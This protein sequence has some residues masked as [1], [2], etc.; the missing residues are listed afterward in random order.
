MEKIHK[1]TP[2]VLLAVIAM[3]G[4]FIFQLNKE[5]ENLECDLISAFFAEREYTYPALRELGF[6]PTELGV[7]VD[8]PLT[9]NLHYARG[10][11]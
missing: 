7:D 9:T 10:C 6:E 8:N 5:V 1:L 2:V 11:K 4:Y 3:Q